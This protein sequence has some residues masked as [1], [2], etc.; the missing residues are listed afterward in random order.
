MQ[1][2]YKISYWKTR[3]NKWWYALK[4]FG[5]LYIFCLFILQVASLKVKINQV[6]EELQESM[7]KLDLEKAQTQKNE[8]LDL[9]AQLSQPSLVSTTT[10]EVILMC[11][12]R[13]HSVSSLFHPTSVEY[14]RMY[15]ITPSK[16]L[17]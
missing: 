16:Q 5:A 15:F 8:L 17:S 14:R 3:T 13:V 11:Q 9:E 7:S 10:E 4:A 12:V 2:Y 6:R 1:Q